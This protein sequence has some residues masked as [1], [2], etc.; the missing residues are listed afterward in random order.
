VI[1][2]TSSACTIYINLVAALSSKPEK[3]YSITAKAPHQ[4]IEATTFS[5]ISSFDPH[6]QN[7]GKNGTYPFSVS[8]SLLA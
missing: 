5:V 3:T 2:W 6:G 4:L 1:I 8:A 7:P